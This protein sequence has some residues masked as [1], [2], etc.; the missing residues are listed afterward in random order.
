MINVSLLGRIFLNTGLT[1]GEVG[2]RP[3]RTLPNDADYQIPTRGTSKDGD[4]VDAA[5]VLEWDHCHECSLFISQKY[6]QVLMR[7]EIQIRC[8]IVWLWLLF[9]LYYCQSDKQL[10]CLIAWK[11]GHLH[12]LAHLRSHQLRRLGLGEKAVMISTMFPMNPT[13]WLWWCR[14]VTVFKWSPS[15]LDVRRFTSGQCWTGSW[16]TSKAMA[17]FGGL[18][19]SV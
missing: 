10:Y 6:H 9:Y 18:S 11:T 8:Y 14:Y 3:H 7:S 4:K 15:N 19:K 2:P 16:S 1:S 5:Y 17:I 13:W 12:R